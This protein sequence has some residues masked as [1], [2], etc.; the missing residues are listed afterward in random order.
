[1]NSPEIT[2]K[3]A[4]DFVKQASINSSA[5]F[6]LNSADSSLGSISRVARP[7]IRA[8]LPSAGKL[9][10]Q[11]VE[12]AIQPTLAKTV[13][14]INVLHNRRKFLALLGSSLAAGRQMEKH[15][16]KNP[17]LINHAIVDTMRPDNIIRTGLIGPKG[18]DAL[19]I[20][21]GL[22]QEDPARWA[23]INMLGASVSPTNSRVRQKLLRNAA[24][25][26]GITGLGALG[27]YAA[28]AVGNSK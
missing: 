23:T 19:N 11:D 2:A 20:V 18:F 4:F 1:M 5:R 17:S 14:N 3:L 21:R 16:V 13:Q 7:V 27:T 9:I 26:A 6:L 8:N 24:I 15:V 28:S 22:S 12:K 10:S 25:G